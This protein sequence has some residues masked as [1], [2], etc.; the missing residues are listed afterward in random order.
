[1]EQFSKMYSAVPTGTALAKI[2]TAGNIHPP[3]KKKKTSPNKPPPHKYKK[4]I[5]KYND[6]SVLR[7]TVIF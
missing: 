2:N 3:P 5:R 1:M 6:E 7:F 4:K